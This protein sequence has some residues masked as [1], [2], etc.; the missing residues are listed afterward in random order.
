MRALIPF[1]FLLLS[2]S[3]PAGSAGAVRRKSKP[4]AEVVAAPAQRKIPSA[5]GKPNVVVIVV[6]DL[7]D[8]VGWL[9]G[10]PQS[11]TPN[12]D[13][14][15]KMGM[16]FTNAHTAYALCN[17]S[18]TA[19]LTGMAPWKSGVT[20][21][22][23]DWRYAATTAGKWTLP[24][25]FRQNGYT[26]AAGGKIFHANHGGPE[27]RLAGWHGGRRGFEQ[28]AAWDQR[29]PQAG[30]QL[31]DLPLHVGQ[32][33]N[34]LDIWH[35]DWKGTATP[36]E[37]TEDGQT[38]EWA[39]KFLSLA[40]GTKKKPF[41]LAVGIY[42][43]HSPWYV[44]QAYFDK[45][46]L[47]QIELPKVQEGD[48]NDIPPFAKGDVKL[49][50]NVVAKGL[51]KAAVQAYLANVAFADAQVGKLLDALE[52]SPAAKNTI[53]CLTSDHGWY[54]GEK[55]QWHKGKL[56]ERATHVPL[57]LS[58]PGVTLPDT[59]CAQPVSLLDLYPTLVD[60]A[61]VE[62]P[63]HLDGSSLKEMLVNPAAVR[64]K[65]AI[66]TMGGEGKASYAARSDRWRYIR[67]AD[68]TEELYDHEKDPNEWTNVA[69]EAAHLAVKTALA[70]ALPGP[71]E[72]TKAERLVSAVQR[73]QQP[74]NQ[75]GWLL[76]NGDV[77]SQIE[78]PQVVGKDLDVEAAFDYVPGVDSDS[79]LLSQG[80]RQNGWVLH[81]VEGRPSVTVFVA[82]VPSSVMSAPMT[83]GPVVVRAQ[84]GVSGTIAINVAGQG[85]IIDRSPLP[86]G[87]LVQPD[88]PLRVGQSFDLLDGETYPNST[89]LDAKLHRLWLTVL[90]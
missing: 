13:R 6:D 3:L 26:T 49:H 30:V 5:A 17:P 50:Q 48:L 56:W 1:C 89:P 86:T 75:D 60:L 20:G 24:E 85:E 43:P 83:A 62:S 25:C 55:Q 53:L 54:L 47:D 45:F 78:G 73:L 8:W 69:H 9:G 90:H 77:L 80:S 59:V 88:G 23:Q 70:A 34:G 76:Q 42:K 33:A 40:T 28:D 82:G 39:G 35:W 16:R 27:G 63:T 84:L 66:T 61:G 19:L 4:A 31:P 41:F 58:V 22:E 37:E 2:L 51:W 64:A 65:P 38:V 57:T 44:P 46:P 15:A 12:M 7:N 14:L 29:F 87:F 72:W 11:Q 68:G 18:R 21:N 74:G 52:K 32:N 36:E 10:H 79:T 71:A 67:Y 81:L